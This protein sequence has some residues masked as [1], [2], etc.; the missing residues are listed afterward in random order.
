M[1]KLFAI[2]SIVA[3]CALPASA[4][5]G[6]SNAANPVLPAAEVAAFSN[7]VQQDLA[8]RGAN[9]AIVARIGR[10]PSLLPEGIRYTH[11]AFWVY[12]EVTQSN[13]QKGR[14]YRVYNLYQ[15][16]G[17]LTRSDLIQDSPADFFAAAQRLD[18]GVI[19]PDPRLQQQL[20]DVITSPTYA[21]LHNPTYSVLAN[22]G[23]AQFQNC[24]EHTLDVL[25]A[26]LYDTSDPRQIKANIAAHFQGQEVRL[27]NLQRLF[28]PAASRALTTAD[29]GSVVRTATFGSI[30]RFMEAHDLADLTYRITPDRLVRY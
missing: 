20:L 3:S 16:N 10:D 25:M 23:S 14:G 18:A 29:H 5:A 11:V 2:L 1:K 7:R 8:A 27:N 12:S 19:I 6:S 15:R 9:V 17:E 24:T 26:A 4:N 28:A 22:P 13:G 21:A 30:A